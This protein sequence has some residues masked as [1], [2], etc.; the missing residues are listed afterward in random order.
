MLR[1]SLKYPI[2]EYGAKTWRG[3]SPVITDRT[4][5]RGGA[6]IIMAA[7]LAVTT[8]AVVIKGHLIWTISSAN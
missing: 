6:A 2:T 1:E 5:T 7:T 8:K 3:I 4:A